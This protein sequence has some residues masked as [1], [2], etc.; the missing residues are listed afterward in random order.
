MAAANLPKVRSE[1]PATY[2]NPLPPYRP[3]LYL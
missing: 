3:L 1:S 2:T